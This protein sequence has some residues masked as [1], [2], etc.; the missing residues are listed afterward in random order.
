[1]KS[2]LKKSLKSKESYDEMFLG[3]TKLTFDEELEKEIEAFAGFLS[4]KTKEFASKG[5]VG[6]DPLLA[7]VMASS[8]GAS[9]SKS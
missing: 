9:G 3:P 6:H 8:F 4:K 5:I 7:S 2:K 1:M